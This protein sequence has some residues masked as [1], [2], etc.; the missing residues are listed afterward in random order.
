MPA[1]VVLIALA[2]GTAVVGLLLSLLMRISWPTRFV[3]IVFLASFAFAAG[4]VV[5]LIASTIVP[6][7][8]HLYRA[9]H[10]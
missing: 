6:A 8:G 2:A 3:F 5:W 7:L 1:Y 4:V 9:I 10:P